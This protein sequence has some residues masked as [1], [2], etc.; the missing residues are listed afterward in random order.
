MNA[1]H[2]S[3]MVSLPCGPVEQLKQI[4]T[5]TFISLLLGQRWS[6]IVRQARPKIISHN[7]IS[8]HA[9]IEQLISV[10]YGR[11]NTL[12]YACMG[13]RSRPTGMLCTSIR[14]SSSFDTAALM[15]NLFWH[16]VILH[17]TMSKNQAYC[18]IIPLYRY[19]IRTLVYNNNMAYIGFI[20][21]NSTTKNKDI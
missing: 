20:V 5:V 10:Q 16:K 2:V 21:C 15:E 4:L 11:F 18:I 1:M 13:T 9:S 14:N 8:F 19:C 17:V 7:S 12:L 3:H 6:V